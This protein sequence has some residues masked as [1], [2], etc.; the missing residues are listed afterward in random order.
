MVILNVIPLTRLPRSQPQTYSY[1]SAANIP[2]YSLV[3]ITLGHREIPALV[4]LVEQVTAAKKARLKA[5]NF[6]LRRINSTI[7]DWPA[8]D[9]TSVKLILECY[10]Q[11]DSGLGLWA[12]LAVPAPLLKRK[13]PTTPYKWPN[14][15]RKEKNRAKQSVLAGIHRFS[16]AEQQIK[17]TLN[18]AEQVLVL[19]PTIQRVRFWEKRLIDL[20][21]KIA[22]FTSNYTPSK[23]EKLRRSV[24]ENRVRVII[25]TRSAVFLPMPLLGLIVL[26]EEQNEAYYSTDMQPLYD[27]RSVAALKAKIANTP[28]LSLAPVPSIETRYNAD[29]LTLTPTNRP[30][31]IEHLTLNESRELPILTPATQKIISRTLTGNGKVLMYLNR[32]GQAPFVVCR[33]C[34][35]VPRCPHCNLSLTLHDRQNTKQLICHTC[36]YE[37]IA[38][39]ICPGCRACEL[40]PFDVGTE[41]LEKFSQQ[42]WPETLVSRIDSEN[43]PKVRNTNIQKFEES[44]KGAILIGTTTILNLEESVDIAIAPRIDNE[45]FFPNYTDQER[46]FATIGKLSELAKK[47]VI[48]QT[49]APATTALILAQKHDY[50]TFYKRELAIREALQFPPYAHLIKLSITHKTPYKSVQESNI[51]KEKLRTA[52]SFYQKNNPNFTLEILGP[53]KGYRSQVHGLHKRSI[54]IKTPRQFNILANRLILPV[55]PDS[56][57]VEINPPNILA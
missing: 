46:A 57:R 40:I 47:L 15:P 27:T 30:I 2:L 43:S 24:I 23:R 6:T 45:L 37:Q 54:I 26:D 5:E 9:Q 20:K 28:L 8:L 11:F 12:K 50:N 31:Q 39:S 52:A 42:H 33:A 16:Q 22:T 14:A 25:G 7:T 44:A 10:R 4:I 48:V 51:L 32:R 53:L 21:P 29:D 18:Q 41:S 34:G 35:F 38:P 13:T 19:A 55:V 1:F 36:G 3:R 17:Q 49:V 56:W